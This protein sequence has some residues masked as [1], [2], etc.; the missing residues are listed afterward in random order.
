MQDSD[1][2]TNTASANTN[3]SHS[4]TLSASICFSVSCFIHEMALNTITSNPSD[5]TDK[6]II[7]YAIPIESVRENTPAVRIPSGTMTQA[8]N[9][10]V[11]RSEPPRLVCS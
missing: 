3:A 10:M 2:L 5:A 6:L 7:V 1:R 9:I 4:H 11:L 8:I